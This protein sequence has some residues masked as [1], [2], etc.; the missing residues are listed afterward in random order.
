MIKNNIPV[1]LLLLFAFTFV[2]SE[3]I[4][5]NWEVGEWTITF[6]DPDRSG[7]NIPCQV[8]YPAANA[9]QNVP[10]AEGKFP[11]VVF[12]HGFVMNVGAYSSIAESLAEQGFIVLLVNTETGFS[13]S[14]TNFARDLAFVADD[15]LV[16]GGISGDFFF[17]KVNGKFAIGGHSM[18]GGCT[19]LS[20]QYLNNDAA[21]LFTFAAAETNPS[22]IE[23]MSSLNTPNLLLAGEL[24]CVAPPEDHQIPMYNAQSG[25]DC[26]F[27]V[28]IEGG[29][30][31]QFNDFNFNCNLGESFCSPSGGL[32]RA[33]QIEIV[34]GELVPWLHSFLYQDLIMEG[35]ENIRGED[36]VRTGETYIFEVDY[37]D[38]LNYDWRV[39][40][41]EIITGEFTNRIEIFISEDSD[42]DI[43]LSLTFSDGFCLEET[44]EKIV[45]L[46]K[47][48]SVEDQLNKPEYSLIDY[49]G[50]FEVHFSQTINT[51]KIVLT[52]VIGRVNRLFRYESNS[53]FQ[54][55]KEGLIPGI[56]FLIIRN[57]ESSDL[58]VKLQIY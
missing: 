4:S 34:L 16:R 32:D 8:Y 38:F 51:P 19:Y 23:Q 35:T 7:R 41:A 20:V 9:G 30:H 36:T 31:C 58:L 29:Y 40:G 53:V 27:Y 5:Q 21:C 52:D 3:L 6:T 24:D 54:I 55:S 14:H 42:E 17:G 25:D 15:V 47:S 33:S 13:P 48:V 28:E 50:Y 22:A 39:W 37:F 10:L 26:K 1:T 43:E 45:T 46:E 57:S 49:G 2:S 18:G 11:H 56:Y 44:L 12:G